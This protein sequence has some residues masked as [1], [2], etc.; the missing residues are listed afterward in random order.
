MPDYEARDRVR[1]TGTVLV[2]LGVSMWILYAVGRYLLGWDI[3]DRQFLPYHLATILPGMVLRYH[4][5]FFHEFPKRFFRE[6]P[7]NGKKMGPGLLRPEASTLAKAFVVVNNFAHDLFTG[8][9]T[10]SLLVILLLDRK[11]GSPGGMLIASALHE[12]MRTF[13]WVGVASLVAVLL[14]GG[15]RLF[16][17]KAEGAGQDSEIK[18]EL[19]IVKHVLFAF[20][21]IGGTYAAHRVAFS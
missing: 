2:G 20:V 11:S 4:R 12:V 19:L 16:Y 21:F 7:E 10:S 17:Y 18:K 5:F 9:W 15:V 6:R 13:F 1:T 3:T 14:S 8:L